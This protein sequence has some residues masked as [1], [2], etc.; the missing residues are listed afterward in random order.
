M[1]FLYPLILVSLVITTAVQA[2]APLETAVAEFRD[3]PKEYRLDGV[4]EAVHQSTVSAQTGGQIEE[5]FFDVDD[6][7]EQGTMIVR[8]KDTEQRSHLTQAGAELK[9]ATAQ[10]QKSSKEYQRIKEVFEKKLVSSAAMDKAS[11]SL[12]SARA[13]REAAN[14]AL[15]RAQEQLDY[16]LVRAPY[17]GIVT[18]RHIEVGEIAAPG[19]KLMSGISLDQL[20]V[21]VDVPQSLIPAIRERGKASVQQP[22]NGY[23]PAK[24]I[25][26]FP[27]A[28]H[29]SNTFK[30]RLE[31]AEGI[32]GLFPGMFVKTTFTIG[33]R[34]ALLIPIQAVVYRSEVTGVYVL[35]TNG[36]L[37]LRHIRVGHKVG[38][39]LISVLA[40]LE[41]GEQVA[42]NPIAAGKQLKKQL[43][44]RKDG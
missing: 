25:T 28:D 32:S 13:Q 18:R 30:V 1:R 44:E 14:A 40:G 12:K 36:H 35:G 20:R 9:S 5:I 2:E 27:F 34:R 6:Y 42:L 4:V 31:L 10:L 39:R 37:S 17:S 15:Q 29:G 38:G 23:I 16:T 22:G 21:N 26:I 41:A 33:T 43:S 11:A 3:L 7:V 24:K 8:L 19:E